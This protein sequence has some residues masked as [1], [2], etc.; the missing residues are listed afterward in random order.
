MKKLVALA[1]AGLLLA[2]CSNDP[3]AAATVNG[4]E[5]TIEELSET[6]SYLRDYGIDWESADVLN[7]LI[8]AEVTSDVAEAGEYDGLADIQEQAE[9]L[10]GRD[11]NPEYSETIEEVATYIALDQANASM[12]LTMEELQEVSTSLL[13][14]DVDVNPRF[15]EWDSEIGSLVGTEYEWQVPSTEQTLPGL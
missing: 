14:A 4:E 11:D 6:Q 8:V 9:V 2:A 15:G 5:I 10:L 13:E 7:L 1:G 12:L 3:S